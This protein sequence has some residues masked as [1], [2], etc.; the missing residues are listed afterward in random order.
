MRPLIKGNTVEEKMISIERAL[1]QMSNRT[2]KTVVVETPPIPFSLFSQGA[3]VGNMI[4]AFMFPINCSLENMVVV[5]E[6]K[7][8][9]K[10]ILT[11]TV[12]S[13]TEKHDHAYVLALG[14]NAVGY[15]E[16]LKVGD[17]ILFRLTVAEFAKSKD[18]QSDAL[19]T[20]WISFLCI[21]DR[22]GMSQEEFLLDAVLKS[23]EIAE[24]EE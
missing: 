11:I 23:V 5:A 19:E 20:I 7:G 24:A 3:I 18:I 22:K 4:G 10:G 8:F 21:P 6:G 16:D 17:R 15:K 13:G 9:S 14:K 2:H 12:L 1:I